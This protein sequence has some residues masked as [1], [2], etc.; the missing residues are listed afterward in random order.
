MTQLI[1]FTDW[2][3]SWKSPFDNLQT[4]WKKLK[5][6]LESWTWTFHK[7]QYLK[8]SKTNLAFVSKHPRKKMVEFTDSTLTIY[9]PRN[10]AKK[11]QTVQKAFRYMLVLNT[12][13]YKQCLCIF[14]IPKCKDLHNFQTRKKIRVPI[15]C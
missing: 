9:W 8:S 1:Q 15:G 5:K 11:Q 7:K 12:F 3:S 13:Q 10:I 6:V 2:K 14:I 4:R